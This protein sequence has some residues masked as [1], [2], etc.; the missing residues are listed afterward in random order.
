MLF[1]T[2][3]ISLR[4]KP[5]FRA[6]SYFRT[7]DSTLS[8]SECGTEPSEISLGRGRIRQT[9]QVLRTAPAYLGAWPGAGLLDLLPVG[10]VVVQESNS[11]ERLPL[12]LWRYVS[13]QF[14][15]VSFNQDVLARSVSDLVVE[16]REETAQLHVHVGDVVHSQLSDWFRA[17]NFQ[18]AYETSVGNTR[19][20]NA[21]SQQLRVP[22]ADSRRIAEE[23][24]DIRL[25]CS[26]G[27]Q[28][29]LVSA[30]NSIY[31]RSD[32][33]SE[34]PGDVPKDFATPLAKWFRGLDLTGFV[35][36]NDLRLNGSIVMEQVKPAGPKIPMLDF[37][38]AKK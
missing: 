7:L 25:T 31:W 27:G 32:A 8:S 11:L 10:G 5:H 2:M 9:L 4:H 1:T 14:S 13:D 18:R 3:E 23:V 6:A 37:F 19:F 36:E 35:G 29:Q 28:Y 21:I 16:Q 24:L 17:L 26:M 22:V 30:G 12:G 34:D 38:R 33:W 15:V 20:L